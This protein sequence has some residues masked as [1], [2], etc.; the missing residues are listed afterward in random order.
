MM[1]TENLDPYFFIQLSYGLVTLA[2]GGF[3]LWLFWDRMRLAR[4]RDVMSA[5]SFKEGKSP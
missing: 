5:P 2:I 3:T 1:M 4:M